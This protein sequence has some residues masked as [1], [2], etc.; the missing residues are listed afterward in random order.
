[1]SLQYY[2]EAYV[3]TEDMLL[4]YIFSCIISSSFQEEELDRD[5]QSL[6]TDMAPVY[7]WL[8][9]KAYGNQV[10]TVSL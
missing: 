8:A 6:A 3:L 7:K 2:N 1:M 10:W 9:P 4:R 5:I